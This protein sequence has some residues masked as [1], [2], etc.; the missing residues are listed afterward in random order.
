MPITAQAK[1]GDRLVK[2]E[3]G[4]W[5]SLRLDQPYNSLFKWRVLDLG[6]NIDQ[7][8]L[9]ITKDNNNLDAEPLGSIT[10][11]RFCSTR[12]LGRYSRRRCPR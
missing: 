2:G 3:D 11:A 7:S 8:G 5:H 1:A 10:A 12:C 6:R 4:Q 9:E